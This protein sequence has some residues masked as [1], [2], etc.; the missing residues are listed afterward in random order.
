MALPGCSVRI[1]MF[2][3]RYRRAYCEMVNCM[4]VTLWDDVGRR[5]PGVPHYHVVP[6]EP[7]LRQPVR[8]AAPWERPDPPGKEVWPVSL[9][10]VV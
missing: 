8:C 9:S 4:R 3:T 10:A 7:G 5:I 6:A 2:A 1:K